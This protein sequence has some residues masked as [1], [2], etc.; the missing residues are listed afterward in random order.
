MKIID[1]YISITLLITTALALTVLLTLFALLSLIDQLEETGRGNYDVVTAVQYVFLTLPRIAYELFPIAAVIGGMTTLG[2][3]S[4][5][6]E[7]VI[8]RASGTSL[9]RLAYAMAKGGLIVVVITII[10]GEIIAPYSEQKAQHLRSIALSEQIALKTKN[11]FWSRD[12]SSFINIRRILPG[13][14]IEEIYIYEFDENDHLRVATHAN[15]ARYLDNKWLL[16]N[17]QQSVIESDHVSEREIELAAWNSLLNPDV[18][19]LVAVKPQYLTIWGLF[20]Y[21]SY[22]KKNGQNS[23]QYEQALWSKLVS[24]ITI[25]AMIILAV[26]LVS[27]Y[28]KIIAVSQRVFIGCF[29]GVG[30]HIINQVSGH[31]GVVYSINSFI[32][33]TFPTMCIV[34]LVFWLIYKKG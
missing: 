2:L 29:I 22:L 8:I 23:F 19:N 10:V 25:I 18:I 20:E 32:S 16:E 14:Q 33:A 1:R 27:A 21:I 24:P 34:F 7:L 13:D 3:L 30:F 6:S 15:Q 26:P 9:S 4:Y 12:G 28:S 17:I 5:N 31:M 11:M